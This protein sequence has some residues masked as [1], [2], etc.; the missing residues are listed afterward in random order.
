MEI[1][2]ASPAPNKLITAGDTAGGTA[3]S[4]RPGAAAAPSPSRYEAQKRRDWNTFIQYFKNHRPPLPPLP[5]LRRP[6]PPVPHLLGSVRQNQGSRR[7]LPFLR[8][9]LPARPLPLPSPPGLGQPRRP[10]RPPPRRLRGGRRPPRHQ[11]F[12]RAHRPP[13]P[14]RGPPAPVQGPRDQLRQEE[15]PETASVPAAAAASSLDQW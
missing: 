12:R 1:P 3:S 14:P 15:A 2:P 4:P 5:L 6:H 7:R 13:L 8:P 9:P 10:R 11:P